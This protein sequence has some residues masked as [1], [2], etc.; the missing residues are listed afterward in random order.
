MNLIPYVVLWSFLALAVLGLALYRK[1]LTFHGDDE[2]LHLSAS[3]EKLIPH[4]VTLARKLDFVDRWGK[5]LTVCC[6]V[7]GIVIAAMFVI[8]TWQASLQIK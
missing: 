8:L 5:T 7:F 3:E 4:Q 1:V 2:F 6:A